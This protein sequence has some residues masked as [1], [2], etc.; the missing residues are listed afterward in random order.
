[1]NYVYF[2]LSVIAGRMTLLKNL[3]N[4][5][6][7]VFLVYLFLCLPANAENYTIDQIIEISLQRNELL[8]SARLMLQ[9]YTWQKKEVSVP[10]NPVISVLSG[11]KT[12]QAPAAVEYNSSGIYY[13]PGSTSRGTFNGVS[14]SVPV[15]IPGK[16]NLE[17]KIIDDDRSE[18]I[19][20]IEET[21]LYLRH[22]I[23]GLLYKNQSLQEKLEHASEEMQRMQ[24]IKTYISRKPK[25]SPRV[26]LDASIVK[27][28]YL[29]LEKRIMELNAERES[30]ENDLA[31][32]H[33][34]ETTP[35][36][37]VP[38]F[39]KGV[40]VDTETVLQQTLENNPTIRKRQIQRERIGREIQLAK[41]KK[42]PDVSLLAQ[43]SQEVAGARDRFVNFGV[44]MEL[45][46]FNKSGKHSMALQSRLKSE[47]ARNN[48]ITGRL[49]SDAQK[50]LREYQS[51]LQIVRKFPYSSFH[52]LHNNL[53]FAEA[54]FKKG[55]VSVGEFMDFIDKAHDMH[56]EIVE[57]QVKLLQAYL[58]VLQLKGDK[59][60]EVQ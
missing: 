32:F 16:R 11:S 40:A 21:E 50:A 52:E 13:T 47:E 49:K 24:L 8:K 60:F 57:A 19:V 39:E 31:F 26:R 46:V 7:V 53:N 20:T 43:Y 34:M 1:M 45:P 23:I 56:T 36:V 6:I 15:R 3:A 35:Q 55:R 4:Q 30:V 51:Q 5:G 44:S 12:V 38:W 29:M 9:S 25:L 54:E 48:F 28:R 58:T 42:I 37:K 14:L 59:T 17:K 33:G 27:N 22:E 41:K 18:A 2:V 10:G